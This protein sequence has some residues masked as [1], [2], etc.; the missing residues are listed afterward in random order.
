MVEMLDRELTRADKAKS[1][2]SGPTPADELAK[3]IPVKKA[4]TTAPTARPD[5]SDLRVCADRRELAEEVADLSLRLLRL[6]RQ[7]GTDSSMKLR[8]PEARSG[9]RS[10]AMAKFVFAQRTRM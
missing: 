6:A 10:R 7:L 2:V 9:T 8:A 5:A 3:M 1:L 4:T